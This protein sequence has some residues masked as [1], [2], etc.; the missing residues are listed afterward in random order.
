MSSLAT[1]KIKLKLIELWLGPAHLDPP[2]EEDLLELIFIGQG[3]PG[4]VDRFLGRD[5]ITL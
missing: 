1:V 3:P 2:V 5:K 4:Q